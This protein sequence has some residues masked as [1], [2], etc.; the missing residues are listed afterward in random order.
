MSQLITVAQSE[1]LTTIEEQVRLY[2]ALLETV[3][4][5][6]EILISSNLD[7]LNDNNRAKEAILL[8]LQSL[9]E[10]RIGQASVLAAELKLDPGAPR[11]LD[12]ARHCGGEVGDRLRNFHSV[13]EILLKRVQELNKENEGL[14]QAALQHVT[15]AMKA[16][17]NDLQEKPTYQRKGEVNTTAGATGHL[18]S[19]EA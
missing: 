3:R 15:G 14:V 11:L 5:E 4:R 18:V 12:L 10:T 1:I 17:R 19:R 2:R 7:E 13:L 6:K 9:E 8:K 16:I